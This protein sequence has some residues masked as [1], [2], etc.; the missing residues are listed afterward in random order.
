MVGEVVVVDRLG[1]LVMLYVDF[2]E[3]FMLVLY[4]VLWFVGNDVGKGRFGLKSD[5]VGGG[6]LEGDD[7]SGGDVNG[8][9]VK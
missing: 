7:V 9:D 6:G 1:D 3:W 4:L 8:G 2:Y 5:E